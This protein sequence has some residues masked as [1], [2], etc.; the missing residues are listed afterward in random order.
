MKNKEG[1][2]GVFLIHEGA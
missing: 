2:S 1:S